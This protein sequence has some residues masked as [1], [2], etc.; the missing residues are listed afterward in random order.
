[1]LKQ[2]EIDRFIWLWRRR[3]IVLVVLTII[4][5]VV[6]LFGGVAF[7]SMRRTSKRDIAQV[8]SRLA[9]TERDLSQATVER[10][11]TASRLAPFMNLAEQQF[12]SAP[13]DERLHL[14]LDHIEAVTKAASKLPGRR[15]LDAEAIGR[16]Q[17]K[18][19]RAPLLDIEVGGLMDDKESLALAEE[20]KSTFEGIGFKV[21]ELV[22][23]L[24][25]DALV[26]VSIYSKHEFNTVLGEAIGQIFIEL[27]Q[28]PNGWLEADMTGAKGKSEPQPDLKIVVGHR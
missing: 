22:H 5:F 19:N 24:P 27:G 11:E 4:T 23:Y 13:S 8:Q 7:F 9:K 14:L 6:V 1:M 3:K 28:T 21:R 17:E 2:T 10:D 15:H 16:I 12:P 20:L 25:Q 26:G 18:L